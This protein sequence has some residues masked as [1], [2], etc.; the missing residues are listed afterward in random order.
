MPTELTIPLE[1]FRPALILSGLLA[2]W[3]GRDGLRALRIGRFRLAGEVHQWMYDRF[4]L[5]QILED[6]GFNGVRVVDYKASSIPSW[7]VYGLDR[8]SDNSEYKPGSLYMEAT[9]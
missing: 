6:V 3:L 5:K 2:L 9:E 7:D 1:K 8:N 4:N